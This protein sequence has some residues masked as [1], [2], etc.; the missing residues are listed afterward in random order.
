M[1]TERWQQISG[2]WRLG[3]FRSR[4]D[5]RANHAYAKPAK[6]TSMTAPITIKKSRTAA[7][8]FKH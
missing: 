6:A 4:G 7:S 5:G 2:D 1:S 8:P 3:Y